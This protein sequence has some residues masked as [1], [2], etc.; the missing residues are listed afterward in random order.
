MSDFQIYG[1]TSIAYLF[2]A[3]DNLVCCY[4]LSYRAMKVSIK[5]VILDPLKSGHK[6]FSQKA[7]L[8]FTSHSFLNAKEGYKEG[9]RTKG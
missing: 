2:I 3:V 6:I 9:R 4:V 1:R 8:F 5:N 7:R